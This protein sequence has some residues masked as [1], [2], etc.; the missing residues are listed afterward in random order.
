MA[1]RKMPK[2]DISLAKRIEKAVIAEMLKL[3]EKKRPARKPA[4]KAAKK[5]ARKKGKPAKKVTK[6]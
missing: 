5:V 6:K 4:E 3:L 1:T 2:K